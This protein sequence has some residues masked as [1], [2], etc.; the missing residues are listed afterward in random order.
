[1]WNDLKLQENS[2]NPL[3]S[4]VMISYGDVAGSN[5]YNNNSRTDEDNGYPNLN[6]SLWKK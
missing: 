5:T 2:P 6:G 3:G 4:I 1:M